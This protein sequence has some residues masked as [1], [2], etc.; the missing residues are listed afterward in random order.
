VKVFTFPLYIC[1]KVSSN[2][3]FIGTILTS[4]SQES[5]VLLTVFTEHNMSR[6]TTIPARYSNL[7][8]LQFATDSVS[9]FTFES[10]EFSATEGKEF[11]KSRVW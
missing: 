7:L 8:C 4:I 9:L 3:I 5:A 11:L 2:F 6:H 10:S 1:K